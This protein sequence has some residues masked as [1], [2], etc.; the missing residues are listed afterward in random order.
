MF[1]FS[2]AA[3]NQ[4]DYQNKHVS[5]QILDFSRKE[6]QGW[7]LPIDAGVCSMSPAWWKGLTPSQLRSETL[8]FLFTPPI[9][10]PLY[11]FGLGWFFF[12]LQPSASLTQTLSLFLC[13]SHTGEPSPA[14]DNLGKAKAQRV[15]STC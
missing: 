1:V 11:Y 2:S 6:A 15:Q 5:E 7:A 10:L 14:R 9:L 4:T 13:P 8:Q 3:Q 12:L